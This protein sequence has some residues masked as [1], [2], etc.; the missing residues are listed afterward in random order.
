MTIQAQDEKNSEEQD[1]TI[2]GRLLLLSQRGAF[3]WLG[4]RR[5]NESAYGKAAL[6]NRG[7]EAVGVSKVKGHQAC[8]ESAIYNACGG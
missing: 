2:M 6:P 4:R 8:I 3:A 5:G 7:G 1:S